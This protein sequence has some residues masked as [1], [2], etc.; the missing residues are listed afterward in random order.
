MNAGNTVF[1]VLADELFDT[2][3]AEYV[4]LSFT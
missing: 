1:A 2:L 3:K 4:L